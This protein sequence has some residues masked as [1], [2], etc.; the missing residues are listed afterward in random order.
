[1]IEEGNLNK[2]IYSKK[3]MDI[4]RHNVHDGYVM[5]ELNEED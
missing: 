5:A 4:A 3:K 2:N 1:M